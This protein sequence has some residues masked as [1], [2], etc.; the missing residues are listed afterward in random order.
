MNFLFRR[1][2]TLP[3][4]RRHAPRKVLSR[5]AKAE[6]KRSPG[7]LDK[8]LGKLKQTLVPVIKD[9]EEEKQVEK[10][11]E[12]IKVTNTNF[13]KRLDEPIRFVFKVP[14][15]QQFYLSWLGKEHIELATS[16][17][18]K[19]FY[20]FLGE[21]LFYGKLGI[22]TFEKLTMTNY[23][24][25]TNL[26][27]YRENLIVLHHLIA[28]NKDHIEES[29]YTLERDRK[30]TENL[31]GSDLEKL[32]HP[33]STRNYYQHIDLSVRPLFKFEVFQ[34]MFGR[35]LRIE[36]LNIHECYE[37]HY[38]NLFMEELLYYYDQG[39]GFLRSIVKNI[40]VG[41]DGEKLSDDE[42]N[43]FYI[44]VKTFDAIL[45]ETVKKIK[46]TQGDVGEMDRKQFLNHGYDFG[47]ILYYVATK[48]AFNALMTARGLV[49]ETAT[50]IWEK[51]KGKPTIPVKD[52]KEVKEA[53]EKAKSKDVS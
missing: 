34:K 51:K 5:K 44:L 22:E 49:I 11:A 28:R 15:I 37:A 12:I 26:P 46:E 41:P 25:V 30:Q 8:T 52:P 17:K 48:D 32:T 27:D 47:M 35:W 10:P 33:L 9:K 24:E 39:E 20:I 38:H 21:L 19:N 1:L 43:T 53:E 14:F 2:V 40:Y 45:D 42:L 13:F 6:I 16:I 23:P 18:D 50:K 36:E 7:F 3:P 31:E 29:L 4:L